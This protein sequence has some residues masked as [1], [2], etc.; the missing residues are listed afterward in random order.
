M[1][2]ISHTFI[3]EHKGYLCAAIRICDF[4]TNRNTC[5]HLSA[6][7]QVTRKQRHDSRDFNLMSKNLF[8]PALA[9]TAHGETHDTT[10]CS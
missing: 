4:S 10:Y 2:Y 8:S 9:Y 7:P 3:P 1:L 6:A 5:C